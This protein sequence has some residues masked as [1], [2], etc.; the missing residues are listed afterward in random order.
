MKKL[1]ALLCALS[2][3]LLGAIPALAAEMSPPTGDKMLIVIIALSVA[4][5][6]IVL[7]LIFTR[8]RK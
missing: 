7:T 3:M 2:M 6:A 8:N 5:V 1:A 4:A